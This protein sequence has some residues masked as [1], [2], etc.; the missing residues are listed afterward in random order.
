MAQHPYATLPAE[1]Y[2]RK[3]VAAI[4]PF[5]L[6]PTR[7]DAFRLTRNE[8]IATAGSC[9]AQEVARVLQEAGY[10]Y[11]VTEAA[12]P[13]LD[14]ARREAET[15][16]SARYGNIYTTRHLVQLL[17]RACGT[18]RPALSAWR[19]DDGRYV[20]PFRPSV[21]PDGYASEAEV[22]AARD[23]HLSCVRELFSTLDT[24]VFTL[25]LTEGWT[26]RLDGAALPL[27][28]GVAGG[29]YEP[30]RYALVNGTVCTMTEDLTRFLDGLRELNPG[31]R[32]ILTVSPVPIIATM[33]DR[34]V[35]VSNGY[36]KSALRVVADEVCRARSNVF[37][38][39]SYE[40]VMS[41]ANAGRYFGDNLRAVNEAG[42]RHVMRLFL[43]HTEGTPAVPLA[44]PLDWRHEA[45]QVGQVICDEEALDS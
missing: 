14:A 31:S 16:F 7:P 20:D 37:Y 9:F 4:P 27:P 6:D 28:P 11:Y 13:R 41:P 23:L 1:R 36:T 33:E 12:P 5:A 17:D 42:T 32:V 24:L 29:E 39:P 45:S 43:G 40:V 44:A 30:D 8:K 21:E 22:E 15:R 25:G 19:R 38:F 10:N 35:M 34:H 18:F 26:D 3:A 2:W